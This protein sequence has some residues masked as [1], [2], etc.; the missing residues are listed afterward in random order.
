[1]CT[2]WPRAAT[3]LAIGSMKVP[4]ESPG[5][6]GYDVVTITTTW[7]MFTGPLQRP[8]RMPGAE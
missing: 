2:S 1:M 3:R 8:A 7:R 5:K 6:R 4:T